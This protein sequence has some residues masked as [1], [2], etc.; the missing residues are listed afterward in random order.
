MTTVVVANVVRPG[1]QGDF[2]IWF[3]KYYDINNHKAIYG[4]KNRALKSPKEEIKKRLLEK[5][6]LELGVKQ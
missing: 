2:I 4:E 1:S 6:I 3:N 5:K